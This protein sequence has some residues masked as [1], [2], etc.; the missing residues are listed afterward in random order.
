KMIKIVDNRS[1]S[2][3]RKYPRF[4]VAYVSEVFE[5]CRL[6][7]TTIIN[8][9]KGGAGIY[10]PKDFSRGS[11]ID[12]NISYELCE[13]PLDQFE[14]INIPVKAEIIWTKKEGSLFRGGLKILYIDKKDLE[15]L[16]ERLST[17]QKKALFESKALN[18]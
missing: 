6:V 11:R 15:K 3:R 13:K 12:L 2:D 9:S 16:Q 1:V 17:L 18:F 14:R 7:F 10:L 4:N 8:V 5:K